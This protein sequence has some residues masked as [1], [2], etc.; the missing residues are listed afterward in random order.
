MGVLA[1]RYRGGRSERHARLICSLYAH[2]QCG[3][4]HSDGAVIGSHENSP[5]AYARLDRNCT[6]PAERGA[7]SAVGMAGRVHPC[8]LSLLSCAF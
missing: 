4:G 2:A 7:L 3:G 1:W 6:N 5:G 8:C